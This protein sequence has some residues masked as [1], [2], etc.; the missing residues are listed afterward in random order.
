MSSTL[1][2]GKPIRGIFLLP[3]SVDKEAVREI[4][5]L[6]ESENY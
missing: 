5:G 3:R 1:S 2:P 6:I 4:A